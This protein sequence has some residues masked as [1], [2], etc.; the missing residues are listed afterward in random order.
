[1]GSVGWIGTDWLQGE[2]WG[3]GWWGWA[4]RVGC[5]GVVSRSRDA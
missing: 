4:G 1:M 5:S 3:V 2:G